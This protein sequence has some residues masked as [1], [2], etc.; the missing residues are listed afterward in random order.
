MIKVKK[1]VCYS[2]GKNQTAVLVHYNIHYSPPDYT[3]VNF[4][5]FNKPLIGYSPLMVYSRSQTVQ[6]KSVNTFSF[7]RVDKRF[8]VG[9]SVQSWVAQWQDNSPLGSHKQTDMKRPL[10]WSD[11]LTLTHK[12]IQY[13]HAHEHMHTAPAHLSYSVT[14]SIHP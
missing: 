6:A 10:I 8:R 3:R 11:L 14:T 7:A 2:T 9:E 4:A 1:S 13:R 12:H 5:K